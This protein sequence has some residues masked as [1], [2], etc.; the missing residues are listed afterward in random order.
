MRL[1]NTILINRKFIASFWSFQKSY[2]DRGGYNR[3]YRTYRRIK[4]RTGLEQY[5]NQI[6]HHESAI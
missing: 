4:N 6:N 3:F 5:I 2:Y 1:L